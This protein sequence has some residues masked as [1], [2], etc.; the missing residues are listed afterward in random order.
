MTKARVIA[1]LTNNDNT[2]LKAVRFSPPVGSVTVYNTIDDLPL[3]GNTN[4]QQALITASNSLYIWDSGW[5]RIAII[6]NFNPQ[7]I[8]EPDS[9]YSLAIN[10]ASTTI[11]LVATDS[12]NIPILYSV[13]TDS[14]FDSIATISHDSDNHNVWT[15]TPLDSENG[16]AV[17]GTGTVTF[18]ASDGT[19]LV[20]A[21]SAFTL[22]FGPNWSAPTESIIR[23]PNPSSVDMLGMSTKLNNDATY[24]IASLANKKTGGIFTRSGSTWTLQDE[25]S[26]TNSGII[27]E[28][29]ISD[30]AEYAIISSYAYL[31]D[32]QDVSLAGGAWVFTRSGSNWSFQ[33]SLYQ[34]SLIS[35]GRFGSSVALNS[36]GTYAFVGEPY[37]GADHVYVYTRSGS[38]WTKQAKLQASNYSATD[39]FGFSIDIN[40]D[41]TYIIVGAPFED[42]PGITNAGAAYIFT[43]SGSTWTEQAILRASDAQASDN[44]GSCVAVSSDSTYA[45]IGAPFEDGGA[46]DP[47]SD[48]G[49]AYIFTRSG[50]TWTQQAKLVASDPGANDRFGANVDI[51]SDGTYAVI[52]APFEDGGAGDPLSSAGAAYVFERDG[53]TWTEVKKITASDAQASDNFSGNSN[54]GRAVSI[55]SDGSYLAVGAYGEDGG[56]GDPLSSAGAVYIYEA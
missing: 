55:D 39:N 10:G 41:A 54:Y 29:T 12:D 44:F 32:S 49:A 15:V 36:D 37:V 2:G 48:A 30:N 4:G 47:I 9:T 33:S 8:I 38:T 19:N 6:N 28:A 20:S 52:S 22:S 25:I 11:T 17:G 24:L 16:L 1:S 27:Y 46:G 42:S 56:A 34:D 3:T 35:N 51:N 14:D 31:G 18:K 40:P 26:F 21:V 23:H 53:S 5:Y 50:S 45:V 13:I 7:W 43:R